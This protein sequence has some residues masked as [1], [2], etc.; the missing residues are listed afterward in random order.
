MG[1]YIEVPQLKQKARQLQELHGGK[2]VPMPQSF[3]DVPT[4]K[5][6]VI[7][8]DNGP[9]EAAAIV[10][11]AEEFA[12]FTLP[13]DYRPRS[14]VLL[15]RDVAIRLNPQIEMALGARR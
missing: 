5:V 11:S 13:C 8:V 3:A 2:V 7:V 14:A 15:D 1:Y 6:L 9:F 12:A 4:D 10:Y